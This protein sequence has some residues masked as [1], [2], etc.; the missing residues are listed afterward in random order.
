MTH[1]NN[2]FIKK[3]GAIK[4]YRINWGTF[5]VLDTI[6]ASTWM[7]PT[8]ITLVSS[9]FGTNTCDYWVSGG[10]RGVNYTLTNIIHTVGGKTEYQDIIFHV[11]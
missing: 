1:L 7:V 5:L 11:T 2:E 4:D 10:T 6:F 8:G 3:A 9:T